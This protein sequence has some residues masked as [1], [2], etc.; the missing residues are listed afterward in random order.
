MG[1]I[2]TLI[3]S[4]KN[5]A[6]LAE[7]ASNTTLHYLTLTAISLLAAAMRFF[8]LGEWSFWIDE[9]Y[10]IN[11]AQQAISNFSPFTRVSLNLNGVVLNLLGVNEWSARL[12]SVVVGILT[13]GDV[14]PGQEVV[15]SDSSVDFRPAARALSMAP[16]LVAKRPFLHDADSVLHPGLVPFLLGY[17]KRQPAYPG[18]IWSFP[19][20]G[21][22]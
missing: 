16:A 13:T 3:T 15:W 4:Y 18:F 21:H 19:G 20:T 1:T 10:E 12:V 2:S 9:I 6:R 8:K 7:L 11:N 5:P 17:G 22:K 14:L